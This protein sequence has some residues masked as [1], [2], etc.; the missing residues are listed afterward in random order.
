MKIIK[1]LLFLSTVVLFIA[2]KQEQKPS[3]KTNTNTSVT[4]AQGF[5]IQYFDGF[6][7]LIIKTPYPNAEEALEYLIIPRENSVPDS[8]KT[9]KII[10]TPVEKVVVTSTTHIPMLE[11]LGEEEALVGFPNLKYIS[12]SKTRNRIDQNLITELGNEESI[13]TEILLD[14]AP[15]LLIGF[16]MSN[17]NKMFNTIEKAGIP[18]VLNGDWLEET[19]LGRAEWIKFFAVFFDKEKEADSIFTAIEADYKDAVAIAIKAT[20]KPSILSGVLYKDVWN[21]PAGESFVAK[22]LKD[23]NTNYLWADTK[24]KGSLSLSFES[25]Y[26]KGQHA[27]LWIAPGHYSSLEQLEQANEHYVKFDAFKNN[28]VFSFTQKKG[29]TGGALYYE[30]APVQPHIVLK[31]IIKIT[32]PDL[33]PTYEPVYLQKL[34]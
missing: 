13:N 3:P 10:R 22:F 20:T 7:K 26:D 9:L 16:S 31:D 19:P 1:S 14:V 32:H 4:Y 33:L 6:K 15:E 17:N 27:K 29:A 24:G 30:L 28:K 23:A 11:L 5:D 2:C 8:L 21:L 18:V 12:S 25:V 34:N